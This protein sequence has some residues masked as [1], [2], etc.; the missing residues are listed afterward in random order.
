LVSL[1]H[2]IQQKWWES[3]KQLI[4]F[5]FQAFFQPFIAGHGSIA[6]RRS[7]SI[8]QFTD[9][10]SFIAVGAFETAIAMLM[11]FGVAAMGTGG[12]GFI[13]EIFLFNIQADRRLLFLGDRQRFLL[14]QLGRNEKT[15]T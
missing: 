2:L 10:K 13:G 7:A 1:L 15:T 9:P 11:G 3:V 4:R 14:Y 8:R 5:L 12:H 6:D